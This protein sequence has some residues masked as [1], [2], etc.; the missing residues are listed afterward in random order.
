MNF[1]T[2]LLLAASLVLSSP[3]FAADEI[4]LGNGTVLAKSRTTTI[5]V[6]LR[7]LSGTSLN[8]SNGPINRI[9]GISFRIAPSPASAITAMSATRVGACAAFSPVY[10]YQADDHAGITAMFGYFLQFDAAT[11][12]LPLTQDIAAPGDHC[13]NI[14]VTVQTGYVG[15]ITLTVDPDEAGTAFVSGDAMVE[16]TAVNGELALFGGVINAL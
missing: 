10:E 15:T 13:L 8:V 5:K 4:R 2:L 16:E 9:Q 12:P 7:D 11:A 1:K 3:A 14:S 6:Y